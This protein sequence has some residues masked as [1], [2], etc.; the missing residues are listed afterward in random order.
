GACGTRNR[1]A[2]H[3]AI[4]ASVAAG[5]TYVVAAGNG[6]ADFARSIPAAYPEVLTATAMTDTDGLPGGT[7]A[8]AT[9][10]KGQADDAY[11]TY[12]NF[13]VAPADRAHTIAAPGT[14][15][16]SDRPGGGTAVY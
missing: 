2:E 6:A 8:G 4:C 9:C 16:T 7:G 10:L 3:Q 13:A 12:S 5:V 11:A 1:D 15:V 14:C